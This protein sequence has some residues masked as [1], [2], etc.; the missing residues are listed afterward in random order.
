MFVID[1]NTIVDLALP[2]HSVSCQLLVD[3]GLDD[4]III[5]I[6]RVVPQ[7][8]TA[9]DNAKLIA[10]VETRIRHSGQLVASSSAQGWVL[11][12]QTRTERGLP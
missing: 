11:V 6:G 8:L 5:V 2:Q 10:E 1:V 4:L 12:G 7:L 3:I 9:L